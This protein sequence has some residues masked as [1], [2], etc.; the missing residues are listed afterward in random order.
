[1]TKA[2]RKNSNNITS[3]NESYPDVLCVFSHSVISDFIVFIFV[4]YG[5]LKMFVSPVT[6]QDSVSKLCV[7]VKVQL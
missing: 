7:P 6:F 2:V 4:I 3:L 5:K 1:M